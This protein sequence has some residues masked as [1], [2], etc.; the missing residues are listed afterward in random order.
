MITGIALSRSDQLR[1]NGRALLR[2]MAKGEFRKICFHFRG[3]WRAVKAE[4][5]REKA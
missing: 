4:D 1:L 3:L 5:N 2:D